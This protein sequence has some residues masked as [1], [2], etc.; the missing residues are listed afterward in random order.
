M[1]SLDHTAQV[2]GHAK[3]TV[4]RD[5]VLLRVCRWI[6]QHKRVR[7]DKGRFCGTINAIHSEPCSLSEAA[8]L[9]ASYLQLLDTVKE[10]P[11]RYVSRAAR[12]ALAGIDQALR[13]GRDPLAPPDP[14]NRRLSAA[15]AVHSGGGSFFD[16]LMGGDVAAAHEPSEAGHTV[17]N[18]SQEVKFTPG[19][20][21]VNFTPG[22]SDPSANFTLGHQ[23]FENTEKVES[24]PQEVKFT[25]GYTCSSSINNKTTTTNLPPDSAREAKFTPG[26][27]GHTVASAHRPVSAAESSLRWPAALPSNERAL[28]E[29]CFASRGLSGEQRQNV[30]DALHRKLQDPDNPLRS[31][32]GYA[33]SL[34]K[35]VEAGTFQ[36]VGTPPR[37]PQES[38]E[39]AELDE[40]RQRIRGL[41]SEIA[42]MEQ[43]LIPLAAPDTRP[44]LEA[45]RDRL[46]QECDALQQRYRSLRDGA[47]HAPG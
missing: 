34:C 35:R 28:I 41:Q 33:V 47:S 10:N 19:S 30:L 25:P 2:L 17:A 37:N 4:H 6:S 36:P 16:L 11:D 32:V 14:M 24:Y 42:G 44:D 26:S 5:R 12:A 21:S 29:R 18:P 31:P 22:R 39:K 1:P 7:D 20:P 9:D 3:K 45:Q 40:L 23:A 15:M 13:E 46:R 27:P 38:A 8:R 43:H